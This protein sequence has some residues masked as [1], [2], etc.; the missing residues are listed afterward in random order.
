MYFYGVIQ[1]ADTSTH[2]NLD[3]YISTRAWEAVTI[4]DT[5]PHQS[6]DPQAVQSTISS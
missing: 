3:T 2:F 6:D 4:I 1:L 5:I